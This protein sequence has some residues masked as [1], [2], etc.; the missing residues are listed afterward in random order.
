MC[1]VYILICG[2]LYPTPKFGEMRMFVLLG[3]LHDPSEQ[4]CC[5][6]VPS[7]EVHFCLQGYLTEKYTDRHVHVLGLSL[8]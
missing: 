3:C 1:I 6:N 5:C 2:L 4:E 8:H 7:R